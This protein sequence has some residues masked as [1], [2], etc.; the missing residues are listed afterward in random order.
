MMTVPNLQST[1]EYIHSYEVA[2]GVLRTCELKKWV[3]ESDEK[4]ATGQ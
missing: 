2:Y 4:V 3:T 1:P